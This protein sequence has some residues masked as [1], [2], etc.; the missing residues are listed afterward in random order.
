MKVQPHMP[1]VPTDQTTVEPTR[2]QKKIR[3]AAQKFEAFVTSQLFKQMETSAEAMGAESSL[4]RQFFGESL[5]D[6]VADMSAARGEMGIAQ[7]L[8]K[9]WSKSLPTTHEETP[10]SMEE[11]RVSFGIAKGSKN[12]T[13]VS[14]QHADDRSEDNEMN[15][16]Q[17]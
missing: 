5:A 12:L 8:E 13:K 1:T 10:T 15:G 6:H 4:A 16:E 2:D 17:P 3:E 9:T 11:L 14:P 7:V